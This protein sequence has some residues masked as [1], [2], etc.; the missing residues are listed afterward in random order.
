LITADDLKSTLADALSALRSCNCKF[1]LTGGLVSSFYGEPRFT[2]DIDI[3]VNVSSGS[4]LDELILLLDENFLVDKDLVL[5]AVRRKSIFQGL[6]KKSIIK[7]DFHVGEAIPGELERSQSEEIFQGV[8]A[9][10]V[11]KE[12]AIL[13]KL[14]WVNKGSHKARQDIKMMLR[15]SGIIDHEYLNRQVNKFAVKDIL[16]ELVSEI[17]KEDES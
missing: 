14:I 15:D 5:D 17:E 9:P 16:D 1:H 10:L 8:I 2:Q 3:V 11:S 4:V 12:D 6:H 13:S 7:V